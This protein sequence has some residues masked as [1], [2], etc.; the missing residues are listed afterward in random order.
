MKNIFIGRPQTNQNT[1]NTKTEFVLLFST[2]KKEHKKGIPRL[3][4]W[5]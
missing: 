3:K 5:L 2:T 1:D 4:R